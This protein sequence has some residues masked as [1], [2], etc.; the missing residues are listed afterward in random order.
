MKLKDVEKAQQ[1]II[2]S[3]RKLE[4]EGKIQIAGGGDDVLV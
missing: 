3:V 2:E 4:T 1:A